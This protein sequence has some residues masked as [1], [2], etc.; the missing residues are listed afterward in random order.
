MV[1]TWYEWA[2]TIWTCAYMLKSYK[3]TTTF[4][5]VMDK[6]GVEYD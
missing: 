3:D 2:D 5:G 6:L 4:T 1:L